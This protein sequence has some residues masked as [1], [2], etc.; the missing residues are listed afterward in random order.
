MAVAMTA[1]SASHGFLGRLRLATVVIVAGLTTATV[2]PHVGRV[3][4]AVEP[5]SVAPPNIVLIL[6]DDQRWDHLDVMPAVQRNLIAHG[7]NFTNGLVVN[8][9]C[10]PS[11]STILT[12]KYS[13]GTGVYTID[14][15][16][17]GTAFKPSS[18]VAT[19]LQAAGYRTGLVGKYLNSGYGT[20][21]PPGWS[22]WVGFPGPM[23]YSTGSTA[24]YYNYTLN[25]DGVLHTYGSAP[26]DYSTDVLAGK[27]TSFIRDTPASQP[28][29]L[30]FA[31]TAP[32][33]PVTPAPRHVGALMD[34]TFPKPPNY[35][36]ADV[37][38]KITYVQNKPLK[39]E[40][41]AAYDEREREQLRPLLAVDDAVNTIVTELEATGR[42]AN[43]MLVYMSDNG[44]FQGEHRLYGKVAPYEESI[45]IP[46]VIRYDRLSVVPRADARLTLNMDV[47][48]TFAALAGVDAPGAEGRSLLPLLS[49]I[50][51]TAP[52]RQ[53]FLIEHVQSGTKDGAIP[54]FCAVR[55]TGA[56]FVKYQTG[57]E[58]L[59][60][61][62]LD[63]YQLRNVVKRPGRAAQR[64]SMLNRLHTLCSPPPPGFDQF[65]PA[66]PAPPDADG[67]GDFV[68]EP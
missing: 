6:T 39:V 57:E 41:Q 45:R 4:Q 59:Y 68:A 44:F 35:M 65:A 10:C 22:S 18:T 5:P 52:W 3:V 48:P 12:G 61:L 29:F 9:W 8:S 51:G 14:G 60:D 2:V 21:P 19:W 36:E 11:R 13:H 64:A 26:E 33:G 24:Y 53:D 42:L 23:N 40:S 25:E 28:L 49:D 43:T 66:R 67:D 30:Y 34:M 37:S 27:A 16:L 46:M 17:G 58:E 20:A 15:P 47:A 56:L 32:H 1:G 63:P 55:N 7:V 50:N 38:D 62:R 54:T 31:P